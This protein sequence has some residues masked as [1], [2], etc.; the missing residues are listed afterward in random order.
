MWEPGTKL[1]HKHNNELGVGVVVNVEGRF[2]D[3]FFPDALQRMRLTPDPKSIQPVVFKPGDV[4]KA[5]DGIVDAI[6]EIDGDFAVLMEG[7]RVELEQLWPVLSS[8]T[9]LDRLKDGNLDFHEHVLN[10]MDGIRLLNFRRSGAM[11]SL[12][13][14]RVEL[15]PHQLDTAAR[16][17][18]Q[19]RVRWL[20]ADEVG[21]GKTIVAHMITSAMLRMGRIERVVVVA[22]DTLTVQWL[23][24]LYR[25]FSQVFVQIDNDR[26]VDV[27]TDFGPN[28]NPFEVYP[29]SVVSMELLEESSF[30]LH[31]LQSAEPDM[32]IADEA[33]ELLKP[34]LKDAILPL[35]EAAPHALLLTATPFQLGARG[36][37]TLTDALGIEHLE[38]NAGQHI[39]KHVSHVTR[40]DIATLPAR[41]PHAIELEELGELGPQDLRVLWLLEQLPRWKAAGEKALIF[42]EN[43][44]RAERLKTVLTQ[45]A[46]ME[47]YAF[48]EQMPTKERDIEL[49]RFRLS[50][51]PALIS[52][53]AGSEG[54]NFQFCDELV[55]IDLPDDPTVLEQRIGRLDRIGRVGDIPIHYFVHEQEGAEVAKSY[56]ALGIFEDASVGSNP[57]MS[58]LRDYLSDESRDPSQWAARVEQVKA[59]M[60]NHKDQWMFPN[61]H[62]PSTADEVIDALPDEL[63]MLTER[64]CVDAG[65]RIELEVLEKDGLSVYF[66]EY[67]AQTIVENIPGLPEESGYLG[68]FDREEAVLDMELEFF[69]NGHP[70]VEGLLAE[71]EDSQQGR[72]GCAQLSRSKVPGTGLAKLTYGLYLLVVTGRE[73][74]ASAALYDLESGEARLTDVDGLEVMESLEWS[75]KLPKQ[76]RKD[77]RRKLRECRNLEGSLGKDLSALVLLDLTR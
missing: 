30:V 65:E 8:P 48:H 25:K 41:K 74:M 62:D 35:I 58:L 18:T 50:A 2:L 28:V 7:D 16:A 23:G 59:A 73:Q 54:R 70:L 31:A 72:V 14:G 67:G 19:D 33:H 10:R 20:L 11:S 57:A 66:F 75:R 76:T 37:I 3:V 24:E 26:L 34:A 69:S 32:L 13:G 38:T 55:H 27:R 56:Q 53:G 44:Q 22:P 45:H 42:V 4:V 12:V 46:H 21:L 77:A 1:I 63:D 40:K 68:T 29:L 39:L 52:S 64:F 49:S 15:F 6:I 5:P 36:F 71:L 9:L 47:I 17:I 61:S 60:V 43:A 51:S